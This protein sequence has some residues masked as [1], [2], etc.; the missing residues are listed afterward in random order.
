MFLSHPR[1][2]QLAIKKARK[3]GPEDTGAPERTRTSDARFRKPTLYPLSYGGKKDADNQLCYLITPLLHSKRAHRNNHRNPLRLHL[4]LPCGGK[5]PQRPLRCREAPKCPFT[6]GETADGCQQLYDVG[7]GPFAAGKNSRNGT[8]APGGAPAR[9][10]SL[11]K[12]KLPQKH[13][14]S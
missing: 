8:F 3:G 2:A 7:K 9:D 1:N 4:L 12:R 10:S 13:C 14:P 5:L 6:E 11:Q